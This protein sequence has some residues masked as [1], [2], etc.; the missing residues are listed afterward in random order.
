MFFF[1]QQFSSG[2]IQVFCYFS[3]SFFSPVLVYLVRHLYILFI[4]FV[5]AN[6]AKFTIWV[7]CVIFL[8][9]CCCFFH[10]FVLREWF[11]VAMMMVTPLVCVRYLIAK[12][13]SEISYRSIIIISTSN[14][15][16]STISCD[17]IYQNKA[18]CRF[19]QKKR[20]KIN[21]LP[22]LYSIDMNLQFIFSSFRGFSI[23]SFLFIIQVAFTR[24]RFFSSHRCVYAVEN[25]H[26]HIHTTIAFA[27][28]SFVHCNKHIYALIQ[29]LFLRIFFF[30]IC[31]TNQI[32]K[33]SG[34]CFM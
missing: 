23:V 8:I 26:Q 28:N 31:T 18:E 34:L 20:N 1:L 16:L 11:F 32:E 25:A 30:I 9:C 3:M 15:K 6:H 7:V 4:H 21:I 29:P 33:K 27:L 24:F 19:T 14:S 2:F 22:P 10:Q 17:K 5:N 13:L 12:P